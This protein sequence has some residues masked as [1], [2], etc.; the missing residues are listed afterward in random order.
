MRRRA[1]CEIVKH[2]ERYHI[3]YQGVDFA[4]NLDLIVE[5]RAAQQYIEIKS[6]TWSEQDAARKAS[7]IGELLH[8]FGA[9][10]EDMVLGEYPDLLR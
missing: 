3:R 5:P 9:T 10:D 7:L 2:R 6:R 8:I 1:S 4:V